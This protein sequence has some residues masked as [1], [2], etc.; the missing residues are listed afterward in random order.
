M[1][2]VGKIDARALDFL[3]EQP[4]LVGLPDRLAEDPPRLHVLAPDVDEAQGRIDRP[5]RDDHALD[6]GGGTAL[7]EVAVL[8]RSGRT[9][10]GVDT[11]VR[12]RGAALGLEGSLDPASKG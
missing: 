8:G 10:V 11:A 4:R 7:E 2:P 5:R 9:L 1:V 6:Q 12:G 3:A